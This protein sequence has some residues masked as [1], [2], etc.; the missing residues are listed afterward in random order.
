[1]LIMLFDHVR[2][3]IYVHVPLSDPLDAVHT[4]RCYSLHAS[5]R[6]FAR[7][8][9]CSSPGWGPGICR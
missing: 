2:E 4:T 1:M 3:A 5:P 7:R 6:I 8:C 9:S